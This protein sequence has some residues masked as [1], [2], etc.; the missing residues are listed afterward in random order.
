MPEKHEYALQ[1]WKAYILQVQS[2]G[3]DIGSIL[4]ALDS[5]GAMPIEYVEVFGYVM[6]S[7]IAAE[8]CRVVTRKSKKFVPFLMG[9]RNRNTRCN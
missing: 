1:M 7:H 9:K 3:N 6:G 8:A 2:I 5:T 4:A